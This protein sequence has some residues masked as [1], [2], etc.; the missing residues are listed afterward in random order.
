MEKT[1]RV[2]IVAGEKSGDI[3]GASLIAG[4]KAH[5]PNLLVE[6]IGGEYMLEQGCR[7]LFP[8][9]RLSVMGL[10]E[11]LKRLPELLHIR[12]TLKQHFVANPPD[13]FIGIDS[14]DFTLN[15]EAFLKNAC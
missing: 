11:P 12:K 15:L 3:L 8:M 14:P 10:V 2:G 9:E 1:V 6:G 5:F 13:V 4:L 7:S